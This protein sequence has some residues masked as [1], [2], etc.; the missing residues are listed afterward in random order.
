MILS[1]IPAL[2]AAGGQEARTSS[3]LIRETWIMGTRFTVEIAGEDPAEVRSASEQA[4]RAVEAADRL[5]ST[6]DSTSEMSRVNRAPPSHS[7]EIS[8][9]LHRLLTESSE[10]ARRTEGAFDPAI[11]ALLDT[12]DFRG[13][14]STPTTE[15]LDRALEASGLRTFQ[16]LPGEQGIRRTSSLAWLDTGG[17]GKGAALRS[18]AETLD[19]LGVGK[20]L[21]NFGGQI[22]A[23]GS[24][25]D[26]WSVSV[27]H[28]IHRDTPVHELRVHDVSVATS[29][30]S[31]R[32]TEIEG[33]LRGHILDPRS[34][35]PVRP[36]GSVT[37][38]SKDPLVADILSTAL[39]V[40]GPHEGLSWIRE[41]PDVGALFLEVCGDRVRASWNR[42]ME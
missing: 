16:I 21:L 26:P 15:A 17:F 35:Q 25:E 28:P 31:E 4:I 32:A 2:M 34:G 20:A 39:Y 13:A 27:A 1:M 38:V 10:W 29:G 19:S 9:G 12:W 33:V 3:S 41:S 11:G 42:S 6:W 5:L 18:A 24:A 37:V 14:G 22:W 8:H 30:T 7:V 40:M 23:V 36:W